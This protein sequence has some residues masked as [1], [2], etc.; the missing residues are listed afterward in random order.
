LNKNIPAHGQRIMVEGTSCVISTTIDDFKLRPIAP[1]SSILNSPATPPYTIITAVNYNNM[2]ALE[3]LLY[4]LYDYRAHLSNFPRVVVYN[5]GV[6]QTHQVDVLNQL[7]SN[8]LVDELIPFDYDRYPDFW[9]ISEQDEGG[10]GW[11]TAIM[12]EQSQRKDNN[13]MLVWMDASTKVTLKF[14]HRLPSYISNGGGF[15]APRGGRRNIHQSPGSN[16]DNP[17]VLCNGAVFG[18]DTHR[19]AILNS[20]VEPWYQC[21]L[22]Q[23]CFQ[24]PPVGYLHEKT[25]H[26]E[27]ITLTLLA[28]KSGYTCQR[29]A[30]AFKVYPH[31]DMAC[32]ATLLERD[33]L[34]LLYHPSIL[35]HAPWS[36]SDTMELK[37]H[38]HWR[39]PPPKS[40]PSNHRSFL[41][42]QLEDSS[43]EEE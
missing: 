6:N 30:R 20:I 42:L 11:K 27:Q 10:H 31:R 14:L 41:H 28:Y 34:G 39:Y 8:G 16:L 38:P 23:N 37:N 32:R 18:L 3:N 2:C 4:T 36:P 9:D 17:K 13:G 33:T 7:H 24:T 15:W 26:Q 19:K 22:D 21:S 43:E 35:D 12:Y 25:I 29:S 5:L 40:P 1:S